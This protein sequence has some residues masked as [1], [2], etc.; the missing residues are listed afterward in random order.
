MMWNFEK[1]RS[2][3]ALLLL[4]TSPNTV[5][6]LRPP[7][8]LTGSYRHQVRGCKQNFRVLSASLINIFRRGLFG[9]KLYYA[10]WP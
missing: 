4:Q 2:T 1:E 5:T 9:L 6:V 7:V 3:R 10:E 8:T